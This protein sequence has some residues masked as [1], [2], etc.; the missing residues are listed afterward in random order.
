M[1]SNLNKEEQLL[2]MR[3]R[4]LTRVSTSL[5]EQL[6]RLSNEEERRRTNVEHAHCA[7]CLDEEEARHMILDMER[8]T[9]LFAV[10]RSYELPRSFGWYHYESDCQQGCAHG[11]FSLHGEET[12]Q[13]SRLKGLAKVLHEILSGPEYNFHVQIVNTSDSSRDS[14]R[15]RITW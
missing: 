11:S 8:D 12:L 10:K 14:F 7:E 1:C 15:M 6:I 4:S 2:R 3:D 5:R 9:K 13:P